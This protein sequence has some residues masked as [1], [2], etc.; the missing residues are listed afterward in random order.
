MKITNK[1]K[2][3][4][5]ELTADFTIIV[6]I[7][8]FVVSSCGCRKILHVKVSKRTLELPDLQAEKENIELY[9]FHFSND[10]DKICLDKLS[11]QNLLY[12]INN[13]KIAY[14]KTFEK[15]KLAIENYNEL[16]KIAY[17]K[18]D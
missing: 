16:K 5:Q 10:E 8:T 4:L 2:I 7:I 12:N 6:A 11:Q 13:I 1:I 3:L 18:I 9:D 17:E 14:Y 15:Y